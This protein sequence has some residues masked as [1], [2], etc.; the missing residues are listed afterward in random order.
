MN[1]LLF[2]RNLTKQSK[3]IKKI[4]AKYKNF[5]IIENIT[6]MSEPLG[7]EVDY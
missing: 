6:I 5:V 7:T 2:A 1:V 4:P 3:C